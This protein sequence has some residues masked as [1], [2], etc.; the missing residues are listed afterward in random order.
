MPSLSTYF[1]TLK[2]LKSEQLLG[3]IVRRLKRPQ[4]RDIGLVQRRAPARRWTE[5]PAL[6][7]AMIGPEYFHFV[8]E[9][10]RLEKSWDDPARSALWTYNLHYFDDLRREGWREREDWHRALI[11]RWITQN[12]PPWGVGWDAYPTSLRIVNWVAWDLA[13]DL[14]PDDARRSLASQ[15][16]WLSRNLE[17][18]LLG[19]HLF[20][21]L[22]ALVFAGSY[23]DG[24]AADHWLDVALARLE[25]EL[26]EQVLPDGG[27]FELSPMYHSIFLADLIDLVNLSDV[28]PGRIPDEL[29]GRLRE[30]AARMLGWLAAMT[31][32]DGEIAQFN[33][34]ALGVAPNFAQAEAYASSVGI[35]KSAVGNRLDIRSRAAMSAWRPTTLLRSA[36]SRR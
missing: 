36:T 22:K 5:G 25:R 24:A 17:T 2:H 19:N 32:P 9:P 20:A 33:D 30:T 6:P 10:G 15:A 8:G 35:R 16:E 28:F 12:P 13:A 11:F 26:G 34:A 4:Y 1:H 18:H 7:A 3:Q 23:F 29:V 14:L 31:H 21:N 27:N